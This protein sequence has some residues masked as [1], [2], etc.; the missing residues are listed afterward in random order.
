M[1]TVLSVSKQDLTGNRKVLAKVSRAVRKTKG[2]LH[3][4]FIG[5]FKNLVKTY[6]GTI[7][8]QRLIGPRRMALLIKRHAEMK[9]GH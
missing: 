1:H 5:I 9:K 8:R 3:S 7:G 6:G 4:Q 2:H